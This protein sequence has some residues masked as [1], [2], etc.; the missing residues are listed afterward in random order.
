MKVLEKHPMVMIAIGVIGISLSAIFVKYSDA[1]SVV[2]AAYR[3]LW[4]VG[5]M[6]PVVFGKAQVRAELKQT[7]GKTIA[8]CAVSGIFLALHFTSWFESLK[9]TSVASSTA[10]VCTEVIWVAL[11]FV[12]FLKG[13]IGKTALISIAITVI[14]S[15]LIALSD[16]SA[17]GDHLS[18]DG[19]ALAAAIFSAVYTL[20]GREVRKGMSTISYTYIVYFFCAL[21][22]CISTVVAGIPFHGYGMSSVVVGLLLAVF[23][24][25]LGHSIFSWCLKFLSPSFVS[26]SK[27]CEPVV[28]AIFAVFLFAELPA[29]LQIA[30]GL[31]TIGGV[32][33]Y[34]RVEKIGE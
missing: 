21:V 2:T 25:L 3:L 8:L 15:L 27:L 33:L 18:G 32:L 4:T 23:S 13:R 10:I 16:Y 20:I 31:I 29:L 24:T 26:A 1:P 30:G 34:S 28:A 22:L 6:T 14:G 5:L 11:G 19:L 12:V 9:Q 7:N 17:G